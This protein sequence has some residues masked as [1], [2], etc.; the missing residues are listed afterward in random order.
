HRRAALRSSILW[1][2]SD[3]NLPGGIPVANAPFVVE[4][5]FDEDPGWNATFAPIRGRLQDTMQALYRKFGNQLIKQGWKA[6]QLRREGVQSMQLD[7]SNPMKD[8]KTA[9]DQLLA[10]KRLLDLT[11]ENLDLCYQL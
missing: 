11:L 1:F 7:R 8:F 6:E 2:E 10:P 3:R 9:F 4:D 5:P